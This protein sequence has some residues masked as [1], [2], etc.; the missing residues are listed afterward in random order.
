VQFKI[1]SHACMQVDSKG[2]TLLT[3]PW[4]LGS[5]Y[6]RSWWNYPPVRPELFADLQP[7][8]VYLT[9]IHWDHFHGP[10]LKKFSPDTLILIPYDRST[11]C[12]RDLEQMGFRNIIELRH[13][14]P[15]D[16]APDFRLTSYQFSYWGDSALVIETDQVTMLNANDAKFMGGPLDQITR[17]HKPFD[18]AFRSHSSANDRI[19]WEYTEDGG[20]RREED[21]ITYTRSFFN[22]MENVKPRYAV[23]FA[24]NHCH[25]HRDVYELNSFVQTP[26][27]VKEYIDSRGG[28][29]SSE[30]Q[31][32]V[33]GDSWNS[34][35]GFDI[36]ENDYFERRPEHLERYRKE[37]ADKLEKTYQREE[38]TRVRFEQFKRYFER[39]I[40]VVPGIVRKSFKGKPIV[41]KAVAG[42]DSDLF[43]LDLHRGQVAEITPNELPEDPIVFETTGLILRHAMAVNM[44]SHIG[45]SK[46]VVYRSSRENAQYLGRLNTLL[47]A[48]EYEVLPLERLFSLRTAKV[49]LRRWREIL[50]YAQVLIALK[51]G[52]SMPDIES[53]LLEARPEEAAA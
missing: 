40:G 49:Y 36:Q 30:L 41:F 46:R 32:M 51:R 24:S 26:Y 18:F 12:R 13:G 7:D 20:Q 31:I 5:C 43:L 33:S 15:F 8:A 42:D 17:R 25:L 29:S 38:K 1:L 50:V 53:R 45:I 52:V 21:P 4:L 14:K 44:F 11:R 9:H 2:K 23:P 22:F 34:E 27:D 37:N 6:W 19:C 16:L 48:Y 10:S 28:F 47:A 3:D 35:S 39:F